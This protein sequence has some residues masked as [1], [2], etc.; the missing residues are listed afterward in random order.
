MNALTIYKCKTY[1]FSQ[2]DEVSPPVNA[3]VVSIK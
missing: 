1:N 3:H 2:F